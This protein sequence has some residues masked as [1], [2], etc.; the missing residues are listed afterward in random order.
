MSV[1][2]RQIGPHVE[3]PQHILNESV[4]EDLLDC[5]FPAEYSLEIFHV[6]ALQL[7]TRDCTPFGYRHRH[8][9]LAG[10]FGKYCATGSLPII[11]GPI[12]INVTPRGEQSIFVSFF[13]RPISVFDL[14]E[15]LHACTQTVPLQSTRRHG[16]TDSI[17]SV[18]RSHVNR[19]RK[20]QRIASHH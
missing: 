15:Q 4:V 10:W 7:K 11:N 5:R 19:S 14:F 12:T 20:Q 3:D 8:S 17:A 1:T 16:G 13:S 6:N 2:F 9:W 18:A